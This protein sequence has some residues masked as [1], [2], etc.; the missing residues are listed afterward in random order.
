MF[1]LVYNLYN[2]FA[3]KYFKVLVLQTLNQFDF[4]KKKLTTWAVLE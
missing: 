1:M 3:V 4:F 2:T